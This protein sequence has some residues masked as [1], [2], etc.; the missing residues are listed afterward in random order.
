MEPRPIPGGG[1]QS[2]AWLTRYGRT[3]S[4]DAEALISRHRRL[5]FAQLD[6]EV[7]CAAGALSS[8]GI[9]EGDR[10]AAS[11]G[12]HVE[13][14]VAFL[15]AQRLGAIWVGINTSAA[16]AETDWI[17]DD[18]GAT[19]LITD[20]AGIAK[21][22][23]RGSALRVID[24]EP[25]R[26]HSEWASAVARQTPIEG[27][28]PDPF[29][30]A[31][32]AY[33]SGTTGRPKGV[34]HSQHNMLLPGAALGWTEPDPDGRM[35]VC[36]PLTILNLM[37]LG[38][39]AA[40]QFGRPCVLMDRRDPVG[41]AEWVRRESITTF[42]AVPTMIH[43][44]LTNPSVDQADLVTLRRPGVGG[45]SCPD[46]FKALYEHRFGTRV[47]VSY[48]LTEVPTVV[49][50]EQ[51]TWPVV[52]GSC[53]RA[54]PQFEVTIRDDH[55]I[56]LGPGDTGEICVG[57]AGEGPFA[58]V[59]TPMLG[60]WNADALIGSPVRD[61]VLFTGDIGHLGPEGDLFV[62]D[63]K[64][65]L[66]I[67]GGANV[68]PAEVEA[69]LHT[70]PRV[71]RCCVVGVADERLGER[72][73][74]AVVLADGAE[75]D[76]DDLVATCAARLAPY[77]VPERIMFVDDLPCNAMGKVQKRQVAAWFC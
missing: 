42:A 52:P 46:S 64:S 13:L 17:L 15:A 37:I 10:V 25:G 39:I 58:G 36:L 1:P 11:L 33:T 9:S 71:A 45:G 27:A 47:S 62:T 21:A 69:A 66:I 12:N 54:L 70:D 20:H 8:F 3:R 38:P 24:A 31:A 74:A 73:A 23:G 28:H 60:Y 32:I 22:V 49:T 56:V 29:A 2:L 5:S 44:L 14:V 4:P 68:Y 26:H 30:P 67:R 6:D 7:S 35:G 51:P 50:R 16:Q 75:I 48:G 19:V 63:R 61:G 18:C 77:K 43:D 34:V 41:I 76:V 57:P 40:L 65:D 55:G 53:G 72:V 59:Y